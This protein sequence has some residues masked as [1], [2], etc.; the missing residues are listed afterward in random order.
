MAPVVVSELDP[1]DTG[2][3]ILMAD[4]VKLIAPVEIKLLVL[5]W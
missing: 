1:I 5:L 3:F 2:E 4:P